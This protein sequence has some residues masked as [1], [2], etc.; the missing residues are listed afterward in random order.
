MNLHKV[1]YTEFCKSLVKFLCGYGQTISKSQENILIYVHKI[2][3]FT[4]CFLLPM[5]RRII[6]VGKT[7]SSSFVRLS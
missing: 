3:D 2:D 4:L 5:T 7:L 6:V 1:L